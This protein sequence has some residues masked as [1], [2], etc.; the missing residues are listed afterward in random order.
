MRLTLHIDMVNAAFEGDSQEL[1]M[2]LAD[3][4]DAIRAGETTDVIVDSNGN[5]VGGWEITS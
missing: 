4:A 1:D 2:L 5:A 3:V